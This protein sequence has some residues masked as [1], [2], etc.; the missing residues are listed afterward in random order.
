MHAQHAA[1]ARAPSSQRFQ[2]QRH[3][4]AHAPARLAPPSACN[5]RSRRSSLA[6]VASRHVVSAA[7]TE[8]DLTKR[9]LRLDTFEAPAVSE[10]RLCTTALAG[11]EP[12]DD[13]PRRLFGCAPRS[14]PRPTRATRLRW[15]G[16]C[17]TA[18][19][20]SRRRRR[21]RDAADQKHPGLA[22]ALCGRR[23]ALTWNG[24]L[25]ALR[26]SPPQTWRPRRQPAKRGCWRSVTWCVSTGAQHLQPCLTCFALSARAASR[27]G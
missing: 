26:S 5:P 2:G 27:V 10:V 20:T 3:A 8:Q 11:P 22:H 7:L 9:A 17:V 14:E 16:F 1:C 19:W 12:T 4:H 21:R 18:S 23:S 6:V 15:S 25:G 24:A 13:F